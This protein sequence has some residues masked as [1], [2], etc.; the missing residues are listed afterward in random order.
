MAEHR[1]TILFLEDE[2][3]LLNTVGQAL[4]DGGYAVVGITTAEEALQYLRRSVPDLILADIKLPGIDGFDF[5]VSV[6]AIEP[7]A[8]T[9]FIFLTAFNNLAVAIQAKKEGVAEYITKPFEFED[10]LYR[11]HQIVPATTPSPLTE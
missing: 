8:K 7:C 4:T 9:P 6:R 10:L 2:E 3:E 1:K 5:Y 11:I